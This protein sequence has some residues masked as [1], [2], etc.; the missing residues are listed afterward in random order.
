MNTFI[1]KIIYQQLVSRTD[2]RSALQEHSIETAFLV[3][4]EV[5]PFT[6]PVITHIMQAIESSKSDIITKDVLN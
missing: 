2:L 1:E 4:E 3:N 5:L 6:T